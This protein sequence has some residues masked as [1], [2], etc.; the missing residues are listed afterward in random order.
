MALGVLWGAGG[1]GERGLQLRGTRVISPKFPRCASP[2]KL[3]LRLLH[4]KGC[5][6]G[7]GG[8]HLGGL[9]RGM[10]ATEMCKLQINGAK[11]GS[12]GTF[13]QFLETVT[14]RKKKCSSIHQC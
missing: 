10:R 13:K 7:M 12:R 11:L 1:V 9:R 4:G 3:A 8:R 14:E 5:H 2:G 6:S